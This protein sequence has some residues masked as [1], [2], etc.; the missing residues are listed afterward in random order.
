MHLLHRIMVK[1]QKLSH[2]AKK[3]IIAVHVGTLNFNQILAS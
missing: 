3:D 1:M 2:N